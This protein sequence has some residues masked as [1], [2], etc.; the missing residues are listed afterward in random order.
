MVR[1]TLRARANCALSAAYALYARSTP[2]RSYPYSKAQRPGKADRAALRG[3]RVSTVCLPEAEVQSDAQRADTP[4][5]ASSLREASARARTLGK[6]TDCIDALGRPLKDLRLS[7]I[8]DL[9]FGFNR[10][11][12]KAIFTKAY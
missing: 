11:M 10:C 8:G 1:R 6:Q 7:V 4:L 2:R 12:Q 5:R 3:P 9:D